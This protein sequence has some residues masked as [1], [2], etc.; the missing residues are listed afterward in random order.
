MLPRQFP[1]WSTVHHH[2]F[3]MW[4][5]GSAL[6]GQSTRFCEKGCAR[7]EVAILNRAL[8]S[9]TPNLCEDHQRRRCCARIRWGEEAQRQ[10]APFAGGYTG[11][12]TQSQSAYS[13]D[14]QED[15]AAVSMVLE[16]TAEEFP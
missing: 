11:Y 12:G 7:A 10:K 1:P 6:G 8:A 9:S 14:L 13:A 15:R 3:R 16:G 2:Y 5:L 4:R